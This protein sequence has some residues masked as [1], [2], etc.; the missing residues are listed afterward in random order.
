MTTSRSRSRLPLARS[1]GPYRGNLV[2]LV[3][4]VV[5]GISGCTFVVDICFGSFCRLPYARRT[6]R[7]LSPAL[8]DANVHGFS[9][10]FGAREIAEIDLVGKWDRERIPSAGLI[11]IK[12]HYSETPED[13]IVRVR[14]CLE[15]RDPER[16]E[17]STDCGLRRVPRYLAISKM[18]AAAGAARHLRASG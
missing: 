15:Y 17:I 3:N 10:E 2:D 16:L 6:Y 18:P 14:T 9:P 4:K 11:D 12:T 1:R 8:P 13:F 7:W 5:D